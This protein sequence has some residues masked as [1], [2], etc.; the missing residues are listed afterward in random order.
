MENQ[1]LTTAG[2]LF[3][4]EMQF[5]RW[6]IDC[7]LYEHFVIHIKNELE[8]FTIVVTPTQIRTPW[9]PSSGRMQD[10]FM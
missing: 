7:P 8:E 10:S 4:K 6:K 2:R 5:T 9:Y 1:L 3:G